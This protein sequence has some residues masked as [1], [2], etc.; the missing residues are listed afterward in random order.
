[1]SDE[2]STE[3]GVTARLDDEAIGR[4]DKLAED[5]TKRNLGIN[6]SRAAVVKA[7][8]LRGIDVLERDARKAA[9]K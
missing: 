4:L 1:M 9:T 6:V 2:R 7:A 3:T 8:I 5:L